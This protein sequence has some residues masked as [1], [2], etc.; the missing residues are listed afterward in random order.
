MVET[1]MTA[2]SSAS[3]T[4]AVVR[5]TS[6]SAQN[7]EDYFRA[8]IIDQMNL[9]GYFGTETSPGNV[10]P[11]AHGHHITPNVNRLP[12]KVAREN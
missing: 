5:I 3:L 1:G 2:S 11:D 9:L 8:A 12:I 6:V 7:G 10:V 4:A